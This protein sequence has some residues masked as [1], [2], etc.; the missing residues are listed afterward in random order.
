MLRSAANVN[1]RRFSV[2]LDVLCCT[3]LIPLILDIVPILRWF[4]KYTVFTISLVVYIYFI[5]ISIRWWHIPRLFLRRHLTALLWL[6]C[7]IAFTHLLSKFPYPENSVSTLSLEFRHRLRVQEVWF[8]TLAVTGLSLS[9][10][11][12]LELL[13][14]I[15]T[16]KEMEVEKTKAEIAMYRAQIDPHFLF[17]TLNTL[18][19]LVVTKSEAAESAFIKFSNLLKYMYINTKQEFIELESEYE[20]IEEYIAL[21]QLRLNA[22]TKINLDCTIENPQLLISPMILITFVE[23]C[24]KYGVSANHD[25]VI[26][27]SIKESDGIL[28]FHSENEIIRQGS[29]KEPAIGLE[30]CRRR[31]EMLYGERFKLQTSEQDNKYK[32]HL[33]IQLR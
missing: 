33:T 23:N 24:F 17:N 13:R 16:Q 2:L 3:V 11:L 14:Q 21:Q 9:I 18:Y 27:I 26:S 10:E 20:Y 28:T 29:G 25:C 19:S 4:D 5:Y 7:F 1:I 31:L 30:N 32:T 8:I 22:H 15:V 6:I 12:L